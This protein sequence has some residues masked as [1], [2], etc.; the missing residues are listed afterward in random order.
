MRKMG[1]DFL[2]SG[3]ISIVNLHGDW[4]YVRMAETAQDVLDHDTKED[5][6]VGR[7]A[8]MADLI[9]KIK[10]HEP[11]SRIEEGESSS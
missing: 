1:V 4:S 9:E 11:G 3:D 7:A 8:T 5:G 2:T 6:G 10:G